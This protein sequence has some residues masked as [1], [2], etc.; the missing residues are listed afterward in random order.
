MRQDGTPRVPYRVM[1]DS[2]IFSDGEFA[3]PDNAN[4]FGLV[5]RRLSATRKFATESMMNIGQAE[6]VA[7]AY[8][9][10]RSMRVGTHEEIQSAGFRD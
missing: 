2:V 8:R 4:A 7:K 10:R 9:S 5:T 3:G 6:M 1:L